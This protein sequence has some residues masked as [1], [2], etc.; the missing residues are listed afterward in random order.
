MEYITLNNGIKMPAIGFGVFRMTNQ[1]ECEEMV[2]NAIESGYRLIDTAS[3]Y[4]NEEAVGRAIKKAIKN[5]IVRR[6]DLFITTKLW[7]TDTNYEMAKI[8]F[9]KSLKRLDLEYIDLYLI[10]QPY[11]DYYGAWRALEELYEEGKVRA[12][13]VD[14]FSLDRLADFISFNKILP[15]VNLIEINPYYQR[16]IDLEY[17]KKKNIQACA[18]SPFAAGKGNIFNEPILKEIAEKYHKSIA[19]IVLRWLYQRGII[20]NSKG[21][22]IEQIKEN[23]QIFDFE[24]NNDDIQLISKLNNGHSFFGSR[25]TA[26]KVEMFIESA[27]TYNV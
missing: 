15:A 19:Q 9:E 22:N 25:D 2:Y 7:I 10:H 17:M 23:L 1:D 8:G 4:E 12:I 20:S 11:N 26:E 24:I 21:S 14:N 3:A 27:K 5:N 6:T 13:G 18:W 16:N